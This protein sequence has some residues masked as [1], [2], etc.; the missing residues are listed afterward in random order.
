MVTSADDHQLGKVDGFLVDDDD[1]ITHFVLERGHLWGRREVTIPINE[2]ASVFTDA[3]T[4]SL[5]KD[6]VGELP[7][8]PVHRWT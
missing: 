8:V 1:A 2:V 3:V 5:T 6:E 4:L 7:S